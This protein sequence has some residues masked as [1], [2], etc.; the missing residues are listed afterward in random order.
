MNWFLSLEDASEKIA[1][2]RIEYNTF[3]PHSSLENITPSDFVEKQSK[4]IVKNVA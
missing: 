4:K 1:A 2:W 3:R